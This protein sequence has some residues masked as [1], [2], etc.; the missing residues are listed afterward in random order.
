MNR[1]HSEWH[2]DFK[3]KLEISGIHQIPMKMQTKIVTGS[4]GC[5]EGKEQV[6]LT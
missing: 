4:L 3:R 1:T 2:T 6:L 5:S